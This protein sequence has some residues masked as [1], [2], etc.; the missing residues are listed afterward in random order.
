[1]AGSDRPLRYTALLADPSHIR[2]WPGAIAR[3]VTLRN[4]HIQRARRLWPGAIARFVT[5]ALSAAAKTILL[6]P[7]AIARFVT[8]QQT[9]GVTGDRLWPG[10]IA[11]FVT[12]VYHADPL[13]VRCGRERSPASLHSTPRNRR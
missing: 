12:L 1:M 5:L 9:L 10:A 3:F 6:W 11:R 13:L 8:L 4:M 2:L 7:G